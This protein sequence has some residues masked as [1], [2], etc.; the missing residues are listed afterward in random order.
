MMFPSKSPN[1]PELHMKTPKLDV[2]RTQINQQIKS[3]NPSIVNM[4]GYLQLSETKV[5]QLS[6]TMVFAVSRVIHVEVNHSPTGAS[7]LC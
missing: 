7:P 4:L 3:H 5:L 2:L 1:V 6:E